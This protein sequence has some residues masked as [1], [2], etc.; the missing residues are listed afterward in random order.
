MNRQSG[1]RRSPSFARPYVVIIAALAVVVVGTFLAAR[2]VNVPQPAAVSL[3]VT[4]STAVA[5]VAPGSTPTVPAPPDIVKQGSFATWHYTVTRQIIN[6]APEFHATIRY[7]SSSIGDLKAYASENRQLA[8]QLISTTTTPV[9]V[10]V[11]FNTY[12]QPDQYR[13][14]IADTGFRPRI[15]S[16]RAVD[17]A[18]LNHRWGVG[19]SPL[20]T[21]VLPQ[22][23]L[24]LEWPGSPDLTV[25][26]VFSV[27]GNIAPG[28]LARL[29]SDPVVFLPDVSYAV[30]RREM[31][32]TIAPIGFN[33]TVDLD[34][35][36]WQMEDLGLENFKQ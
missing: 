22:S 6:A 20:G 16:V 23:A 25:K 35:P 11:T 15:A 5:T 21:D 17:S 18:D 10:E 14:W 32:G 1:Y 27:R 3:P 9:E 13:Q 2:S 19:V 30:V 26:G 33:M 12:L 7:A 29:L 31:E 8:T 36:F 4:Q 24:D 28:K 34:S